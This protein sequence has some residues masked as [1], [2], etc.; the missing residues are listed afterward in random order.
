VK[1]FVQLI[2]CTNLA[3]KLRTKESERGERKKK[4]KK[5]KLKHSSLNISESTPSPYTSPPLFFF[6]INKPI[7]KKK[8]IKNKTETKKPKIE[9]KQN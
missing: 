6:I 8:K 3:Y 4:S 9:N 1:G 5:Q 7:T 2:Q